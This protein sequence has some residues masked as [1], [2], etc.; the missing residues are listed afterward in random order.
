MRCRTTLNPG[1]SSA[2]SSMD[3]NQ[4]YRHHVDE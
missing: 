1:R 3:C 4:H 2:P